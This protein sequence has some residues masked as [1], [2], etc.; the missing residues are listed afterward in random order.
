MESRARLRSVVSPHQSRHKQHSFV[1]ILERGMMEAGG[2][3]V[4]APV[5]LTEGCPP[6]STSTRERSTPAR[7]L[8][9]F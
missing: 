7:K 1:R 2:C 3:E 6:A 4:L 5:P 8:L 9:F